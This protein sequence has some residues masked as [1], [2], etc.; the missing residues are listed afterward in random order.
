MEIIKEKTGD[1]NAK[2]TVKVAPE[3]YQDQVK[4]VLKDLARRANIKGFRKG[5]VPV[6]VVRKMYGKGVVLEELNKV[7]SESLTNYIR[8]EDLPLL[9]EPL[10]QTEDFDLDVKAEASYEF[11][12]EVGLAPAF[13]VD[14]GLAGQAPLYKVSVDDAVLDKE[15]DHMR[16]QHGPTSN[17]D[18][19]QEGDTLYGKL[20]E[21]D[22]DGNVVEEGLGKMIALNPE[23]VP[24]EDV[25]KEMADGK[26]AEDTFNVKMADVMEGEDAIR[27]FWQTNVSGEEVRKVDNAMLAEIMEKT[28]QFE[29][30]KINRQE[31]AE[32]NQ[33]F[34]DKLFGEGNVA[35]EEQLRAKIAEDMEGFFQKEAQKF[36]RTKTI[37]A[38]IENTEIPLPDA[39]LKKWLVR[40]REQ[41]TEENIEELYGTYSRSQRW[42]LIIQRMQKDNPNVRVDEEDI[43]ERAK[44]MVHQQFGAMLQGQDDDKMEGFVN[45]YLQNEQMVNQIFDNLLEDRVFAHLNEENPAVEEDITATD[46]MEMLK[47]DNEAL[48]AE[49][50]AGTTFEEESGEEE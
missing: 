23:R 8:E 36:Y 34:F 31:V 45:Y 11:E 24:S 22:A 39:F 28:F 48:K 25:K 16:E 13:D 32:L 33:E 12:Y 20:S 41:I 40:S 49:T 14:Y 29:V 50:D 30:R 17:P 1:L 10:P 38:L 47:S 43:R 19:S 27:D 18:E 6:S 21:L 2:L 26:K 4:D 44:E 5:K 3:D 42:R 46:F 9:G 37:K 15:V 7:I 35:N